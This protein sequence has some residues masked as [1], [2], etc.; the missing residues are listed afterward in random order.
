MN[1]VMRIFE[2]TKTIPTFQR[3]HQAISRPQILE[4]LAKKVEDDSIRQ[5]VA[6][7]LSLSNND[8]ETRT[9]GLLTAIGHFSFG[10]NAKLFNPES[11]AITIDEAL[12]ENQIINSEKTFFLPLSKFGRGDG[13]NNLR[14]VFC[15][16]GIVSAHE[17]LYIR[18]R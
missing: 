8:R 7:Y 3:L 2:A 11:N 1:Q 10:A 4:E 15:G 12:K 18:I 6:F 16:I 13:S 5:W 17:Y 9:S 14:K